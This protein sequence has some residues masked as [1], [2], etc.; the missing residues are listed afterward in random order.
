MN[1]RHTFRQIARFAFVIAL[2][3]LSASPS[4]AGSE[5]Q[6]PI[7]EVVIIVIGG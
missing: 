2:F 7:G 4:F 5:D 6:A 3:A 1:A